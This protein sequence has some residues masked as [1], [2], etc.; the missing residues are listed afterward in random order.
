MFSGSW[1]YT[2][3]KKNEPKISKKIQNYSFVEKKY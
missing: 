3:L 1:R 2:N